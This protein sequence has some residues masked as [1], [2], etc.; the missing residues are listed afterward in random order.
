MED[1]TRGELQVMVKEKA[2]KVE[3]RKKKAQA[4][5]NKKLAMQKQQDEACCLATQ[6]HKE[7][8]HKESLDKE[9]LMIQDVQA[10]SDS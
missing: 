3:K 9:S 5:F 6:Q 7:W 1:V 2:K 4:K 10:E 8:L